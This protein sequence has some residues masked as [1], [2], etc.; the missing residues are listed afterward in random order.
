MGSNPSKFAGCDE[1]PVEQVNWKKVQ[2]FITRLNRKT[3]KKYRLPT[4]AEWE[5]AA[6]GG[7]QSRGY[8][9]SGSD[10]QGAVAWGHLNSGRETHPVG[11]KQPNELGLYDMS[12][13]VEEWCSDWYGP[14]SSSSEVNPSG[15]P[16]GPGRVIRG[17][18][19]D[20]TFG[21]ANRWEAF[22]GFDWDEVGFRL[23]LAPV[24]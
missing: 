18:S 17:G 15:A 3:G 14:Y 13:N 22:Q 9:Y 11:Q 24:R 1:C 12:G 19:W 2:R 20:Y 8:E 10:E 5:Y 7:N 4:E 21:V 16:R 6:R 23:V